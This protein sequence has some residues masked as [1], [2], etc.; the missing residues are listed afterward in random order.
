MGNMVM[1]IEEGNCEAVWRLLKSRNARD[2]VVVD[3]DVWM[4]KGL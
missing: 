3:V 4:E 1:M 2:V